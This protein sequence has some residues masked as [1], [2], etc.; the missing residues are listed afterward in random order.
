MKEVIKVTDPKGLVRYIS[1]DDDG[2]YHDGVEGLPRHVLHL[3]S[4]YDAKY[5]IGGKTTDGWAW[6]IVGE[7]RL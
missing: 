2:C 6:E 7:V 4:D 5:R 1:V 3:V